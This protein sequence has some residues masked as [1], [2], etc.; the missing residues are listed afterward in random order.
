MITVCGGVVS[1]LLA[2]MDG[3]EEGPVESTSEGCFQDAVCAV[4]V[5]VAGSET[6]VRWNWQPYEQQPVEPVVR[7]A[8]S[9]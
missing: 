1:Q 4:C 3:T 9:G 8:A 2:C 5:V 7:P 6:P